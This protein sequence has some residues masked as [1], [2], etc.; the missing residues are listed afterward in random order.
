[1]GFN[2][3]FKGLIERR[4]CTDRR[5]NVEGGRCEVLTPLKAVIFSVRRY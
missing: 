1:M 3:G 4:T 5:K 2:S